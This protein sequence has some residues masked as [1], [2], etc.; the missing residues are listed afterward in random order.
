MTKQEYKEFSG[1]GFKTHNKLE[2]AIKD[3]FGWVDYWAIIEVTL[4]TPLTHTD[5]IEI[6]NEVGKEF[7]I[8]ELLCSFLTFIGFAKDKGYA[9]NSIAR[10]FEISALKKEAV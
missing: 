2:K 10:M 5:I 4:K 9:N 6:I 7:K 8:R 3:H 1:I